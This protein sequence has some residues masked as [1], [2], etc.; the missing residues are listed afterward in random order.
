MSASSASMLLP[1]LLVCCALTTTFAAIADHAAR[2]T[3]R[4]DDELEKHSFLIY[5]NATVPVLGHEV[6]ALGERHVDEVRGQINYSL[7]S[8][9]NGE[10]AY[11]CA[12]SVS[13][14]QSMNNQ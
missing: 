6:Q 3:N 4:S 9:V 12:Y 11:K 10:I 8:R 2:E 5:L 1:L 7:G 14:K 13:N